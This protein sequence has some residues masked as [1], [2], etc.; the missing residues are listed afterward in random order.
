MRVFIE[1]N[2]RGHVM[3]QFTFSCSMGGQDCSLEL[4]ATVRYHRDRHVLRLS[5]VAMLT[6]SGEE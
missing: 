3:G 4:L 5:P 1:Y 6:K 2:Q